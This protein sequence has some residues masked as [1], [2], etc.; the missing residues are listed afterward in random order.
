MLV[1]LVKITVIIFTF[2]LRTESFG[3]P[4]VCPDWLPMKPVCFVEGIFSTPCFS[5]LLILI[6]GFWGFAYMHAYII[7]Y[8]YDS[9]CPTFFLGQIA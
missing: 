6:V 8:G 5:K 2:S 3:H 9:L 1:Y 7:C 4:F